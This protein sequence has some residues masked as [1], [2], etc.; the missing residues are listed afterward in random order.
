[1]DCSSVTKYS[2]ASACVG[3]S[4]YLSVLLRVNQV[5]NCHS[6][7]FVPAMIVEYFATV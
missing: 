4:D 5:L 6:Y 7:Y 1:M 3:Y 2:T